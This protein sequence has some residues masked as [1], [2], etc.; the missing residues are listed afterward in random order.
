MC[1]ALNKPH[2]WGLVCHHIY[3]K[4]WSEDKLKGSVVT[5]ACLIRIRILRTANTALALIVGVRF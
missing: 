4:H 5:H 1:Q 3:D 2:S